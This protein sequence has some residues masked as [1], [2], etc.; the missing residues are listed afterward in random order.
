MALISTSN[1]R[2]NR[3]FN[4]SHEP[5]SRPLSTRTVAVSL[6]RGRRSERS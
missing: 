6:P 5:K 3:T 1:S 2:F 4:Y